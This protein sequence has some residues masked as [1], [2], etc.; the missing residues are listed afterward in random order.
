MIKEIERLSL[1]KIVENINGN[2][3]EFNK[4]KNAVREEVGRYL[5][6]ETECRPMIITVIQ[7][8]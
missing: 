3:V 2:Y 4:I 7:E 1:A 8:V 6:L 5:Y